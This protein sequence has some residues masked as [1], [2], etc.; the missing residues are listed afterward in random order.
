MLHA[1]ET[2]EE[3]AAKQQGHDQTDLQDQARGCDHS[4]VKQATGK[5]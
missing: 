3:T 2:Q 4:K 1:S 5:A